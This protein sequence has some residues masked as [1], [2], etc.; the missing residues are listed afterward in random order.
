MARAM[1]RGAI[2]FGLVTVPVKLYLATESRGGLTFNLLHKECLNRIQMK[3]HCPEHGEIPRSDTVRGFEYSKGQYIVIDEDDFDSV[4]LKTVRSHR[5]RAVRR[6]RSRIGDD[7][8]SS[9]RPTTSSPRR[10][11]ARRSTCSSRS[12][13][14]RACRRSARSCSRIARRSR[15]SIRTPTRCSSRPSTGRTRCAAR[16]ARA[17][18]RGLRL[19]AG[20]EA[21]GRPAR[22]RPCAA[23]S[24]PTSTTTTTARR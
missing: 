11:A 1:W 12:S 14:T 9:S 16:R 3:T 7:A 20:R 13:P 22:R 6:R 2:Q 8:A 4:P 18:R 10:S 5:D 23:T 19:Q 21:D 15:A 24:R 17:A